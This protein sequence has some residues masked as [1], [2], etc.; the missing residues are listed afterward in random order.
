MCRMQLECEPDTLTVA[1]VWRVCPTCRLLI[2]H[3]IFAVRAVRTH[4]RSMR[5]LGG[6]WGM[7]DQNNEGKNE[8]ALNL[9]GKD[10]VDESGD[11]MGSKKSAAAAASKSASHVSF[12]TAAR[13]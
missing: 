3:L 7:I 6:G 10:A 2:F 1:C 13:G 5:R 12:A 8:D 9:C 4:K 11:C